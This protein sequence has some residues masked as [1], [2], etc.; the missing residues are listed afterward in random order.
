ML[1]PPGSGKGTIAKRLA[2]D[3]GLYHLSTGKVFS[4]LREQ[5]TELGKEVKKVYDAGGLQSDELTMRIVKNEIMKPEASRGCVYDGVPRTVEQLIMLQEMVQN[6]EYVNLEAHDEILIEKIS[7]RRVCKNQE[8]DAPGY[9]ISD[10]HKTV[11]DVTYNFPPLLPSVF[12]N[13][14]DFYF[15][16]CKC[17]GEL[18]QRDD[19]KPHVTTKR[20]EVYKTETI[21]V[22]EYLKKNE[23]NVHNICANEEPGKLL[24]KVKG[25]LGV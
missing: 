14:L 22:L 25:T 10:I 5:D 20:L 4:S 3:L 13:V 21:P 8:C 7:G 18:E 17:G 1:G 15:L 11:G 24:L 2:K 9:N 6:L 12:F 23:E 19:A 16:I